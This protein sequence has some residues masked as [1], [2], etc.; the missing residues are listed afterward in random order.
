M[1]VLLYLID[2]ILHIDKHLFELVEQY[3]HLVYL[4]LF[5]IVFCE[6][7]LVVTPFLPG[8]SL[9]FASGVAAGVNLLGYGH[10][11]L[12][13]FAAGVLGD[14]CNYF[15]GRYVGPPIF[16]RESR[17][18]KREYLIKANA[19]YTRH[20]GKAIV[21]ARFVPIVRT[22]APFVAGVALMFP[23]AFFTYNFLGCALWVGG[24]V[25]AGFFLGNIPWVRANFSIIVYII[26]LVSVMPIAI[27]MCRSWWQG[28]KA[29]A[30]VKTSR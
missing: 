29:K 24:L 20:G 27:E 3:G 4:I 9:L 16:S 18:I 26:V 30:E 21:L 23:P 6:T 22:F 14:A 19:F 25:S 11:M 2:F 5:V 12:V 28:R 7:G 1:E 17:F 8:D 13:L 10:V 15:I